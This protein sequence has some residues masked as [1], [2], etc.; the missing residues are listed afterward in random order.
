MDESN[1]LV[2]ESYVDD[3][4]CCDNGFPD[5]CATVEPREYDCDDQF[6]NLVD[7]YDFEELQ[8]TDDFGE[9]PVYDAPR[10]SKAGSITYCKEM[11]D[12]GMTDGRECKGFA[13]QHAEAGHHFCRL[14]AK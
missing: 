3:Q 12:A 2:S 7:N 10:A 9:N 5:A 11:C 13:F 4:F 1:N 6:N 14:Y 8:L